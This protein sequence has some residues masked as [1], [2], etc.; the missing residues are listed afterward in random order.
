MRTKGIKEWRNNRVTQMKSKRGKVA[1]NTFAALHKLEFMYFTL[2]SA[3]FL[4][5]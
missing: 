2:S 3:A 5:L 4:V 1:C